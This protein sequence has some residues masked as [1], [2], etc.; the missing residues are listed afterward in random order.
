MHPLRV[1]L[2]ASVGIAVAVAAGFGYALHR[3]GT[4]DGTTFALAA[5]VFGAFMLPWSAVFLWALRRASDLELLGERTR[6]VA[7]GRDAE[8][9]TDRTYHGELDDLARGIEELRSIILRQKETFEGHRAA[10]EEI[11]ASLGEGLIAVNQ[12]GTIVFANERVVEIFGSLSDMIG[13]SFLEVVR[14]QSVVAAFD[15][16][17]KGEASSD[18]IAV[19][20][21]VSERQIEVRV[22]PV[23]A[24]SAEIAAVALFIDI[25]QIER[26]QRIR[27]DFLDDFSH[28]VRTPLAGLR[29][30]A[31]TFEHGGLTE[32][33]EEQLRNVILRQLARI[34]RLVQDLSELNRIESGELVLERRP[35]ELRALVGELVDDLRDRLAGSPMTVSVHGSE[36]TAFV[37]PLRAQQI[38]SNLLDNACKHGGNRGEI[39]VEVSADQ[40]DA[41]VRVSDQGEGIPPNEIDRIFNRFYRVDKSRSQAVPGVGLGLAIAKH[42]VL[43]HGGSI[44]AYNREGGGA[45]F[46]VR[47]P[48]GGG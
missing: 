41:I 40:R 1:L 5:L 42:L 45:T 19:K 17:L 29:S 36:S 20:A 38:F 44:R 10:M 13:R 18:R 39:V 48:R 37:D 3:L 23:A 28:E 30:A 26:L 21:G 33:Q 31:E 14:R 6:R 11:V 25:T 46:E 27:K 43:L 22:F 32:Q 9:I 47:V 15:K 24:A 8:T 7:E 12:R 34:E 16:A 2:F 35:V 4:H